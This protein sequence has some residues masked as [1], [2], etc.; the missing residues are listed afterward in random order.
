[1]KLFLNRLYQIFPI[2]LQNLSITVFGIYWYNRRFGK[3]FE[4]EYLDSKLR[5]FNTYEQWQNY[6]TD[7]LRKLLI[8]CF[9]TV[10]YYKN[11]FRELNID[12]A[13][14]KVFQISD[15]KNIPFLAYKPNNVELTRS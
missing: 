2:F 5:E 4:R 6:Q 9:N 14:L 7:E 10:P 15:L 11:V 13:Q 8:H 12:E 1:M 3:I